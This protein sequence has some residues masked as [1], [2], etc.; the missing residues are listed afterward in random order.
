MKRIRGRGKS[1]YIFINLKNG[2]RS[3]STINHKW[4]LI[5]INWFYIGDC[6]HKLCCLTSHIDSFI[7]LGRLAC[8]K[9]AFL[10]L[11]LSVLSLSSWKHLK[12]KDLGNFLCVY[13]ILRSTTACESI[14]S[15][16]ANICNN[17]ILSY[18][19]MRPF[20]LSYTFL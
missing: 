11:C 19:A 14:S 8:C 18:F 5:P 16:W 6:S 2:I 10:R 13:T 15:N 20:I 4:K 17:I 12:L 1:N 9:M 3:L 7:L